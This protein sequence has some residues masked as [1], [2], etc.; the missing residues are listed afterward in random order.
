MPVRPFEELRRTGTRAPALRRRHRPSHG[1][2]RRF[3][4][5]LPSPDERCWV[6]LGPR[7]VSTPSGHR[8][9][10]RLVRLSPT[11]RPPCAFA[12]LP[13]SIP[14][15]PRRLA[16][17][18]DRSVSGAVFREL[19]CRTTHA[20]A[21]VSHG[22]RGSAPP[23]RHV[24]GF[25]P[26]RGAYHRPSRRLSAPERPSACLLEAFSSRR[27]DVLSDVQALLAFLA[28]FRTPLREV[29]GRGRLQGVDLGANT[30]G[31]GESARTDPRETPG[32][33]AS[34]RFT[35]LERSPP[36]SWRRALVARA[37]CSRLRSVDVSTDTRLRVLRIT[38]I[39]S[40][41]SGPPARTGFS[42]LATVADSFRPA[43]GAS[44]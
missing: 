10:G 9:T 24:R 15:H 25:D 21:A 42:H 13:R 11:E 3:E 34:T 44:S 30:F 4:A 19:S 38:E 14:T 23:A 17:S 35:P 41:L 6:P 16:R 29:V 22:G 31:P 5:R 37:P 2:A 12:F 39:G 20:G 27:S 1:I 7:G 8:A 40:P 18:L 28:S 32:V 33:V 36:V 26:H 43:P